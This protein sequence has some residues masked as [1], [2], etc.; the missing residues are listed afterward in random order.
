MGDYL[1]RG[2]RRPPVFSFGF[3]VFRRKD[4]KNESPSPTRENPDTMLF[5]RFLVLQS[6]MLWQ[7]GFLFY[8]SFVVPAGTE[9]LGSAV[10]QGHI[11]RLVTHSLNLVGGIG[12]VILLW[13]WWMTRKL[14]PQSWLRL[15]LWLLMLATMVAMVLLHQRMDTIMDESLD[16]RPPREIFRPLHRIYLWLTTVQWA[17]ALVYSIWMLRTWRAT[18]RATAN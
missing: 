12:L 2:A 16:E 6:L 7:G 11:T 18:D 4:R 14:G 13:D 5:R 10:T 1:N 3:F 9:Q 15:A 17:A 8:A